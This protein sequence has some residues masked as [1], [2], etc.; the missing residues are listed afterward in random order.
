MQSELFF[1][2]FPTSHDDQDMIIDGVFFS[3]PFASSQDSPMV[4]S[5]SF[6]LDTFPNDL[7]GHGESLVKIS[8]SDIDDICDWIHSSHSEDGTSLSADGWSP[9]PSLESSQNTQ[10][11][12]APEVPLNMPMEDTK[13]E[14]ELR[15]THLIKAFGEAMHDGNNG[16]LAQVI[17]ESINEKSNPEGTLVE[18]VAY[19]M[20]ESKYDEYLRQESIKNFA[21]AFN[22]LYQTL[23]SGRFAHNAANAAILESIPVDAETLHVVDFDIGEGI[24]WPALIEALS[25]CRKPVRLTAIKHE[26]KDGMSSPSCWE[27]EE[28]KK[29]LINHARHFGIELQ[30]EEKCI[31]DFKDEMKGRKDGGVRDWLVFNCMAALPHMG[32]R[33]GVVE[34]LKAAEELLAKFDGILT[35]GD[36]EAGVKLGNQVSFE[37]YYGKLVEHYEA[38]LEA[39]ECKL[40]Y[41]GEGRA[42]MECLFLAPFMCP[43]AWFDEWKEKARGLEFECGLEGR[44]ASGESLGEARV[45]VGERESWYSVR[46]EGLRE[47]EMVLRWK[48]TVLVRVSTFCRR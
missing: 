2:T 26:G 22:V 12:S 5:D 48:E 45:M 7:F 3:P 38:L 31:Q 4:S 23:I 44:R 41:L 28:T 1:P 6:F 19:N 43:F 33:S 36:G 16:S 17:I 15:L 8:R 21:T 42:A 47:N 29:L 20:F 34:F 37:C 32:R 11:L 46:I 30:I 14:N 25:R 39:L 10:I 13:L 40:P 24:Q 27:F 35:V 18:R 9:A